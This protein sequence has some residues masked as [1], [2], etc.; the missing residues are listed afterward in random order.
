MTFIQVINIYL[1]SCIVPMFVYLFVAIHQK[2]EMTELIK[3]LLINSLLW[4][5]WIITIIIS[6]KFRNHK[7]YDIEIEMIAYLDGFMVF[8]EVDVYQFVAEN[9]ETAIIKAEKRA[10]KNTDDDIV[11]KVKKIIKVESWMN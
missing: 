2:V 3:N 7:I 10:M 1:L 6:T 5:L 11:F 4:P 9:E 8:S